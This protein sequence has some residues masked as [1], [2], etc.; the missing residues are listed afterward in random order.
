M[1]TLLNRKYVALIVLHILCIS[2]YIWSLSPPAFL[3]DEYSANLDGAQVLLKGWL[4][5]LVLDPRW[6]ANVIFAICLLTNCNFAGQRI[7]PLVGLALVIASFVFPVHYFPQE[8]GVPVKHFGPAVYLWALALTPV[9]LVS[10][11]M[12]VPGN[13]LSGK[14][15]KDALA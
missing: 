10:L 6:L 15:N 13:R 14:A 12:K 11:Y 7:L 5:I 8:H 1:R 2:L 4:G 9:F 3:F